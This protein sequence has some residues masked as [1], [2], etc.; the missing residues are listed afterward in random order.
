MRRA[1]RCGAAL[2]HTSVSP[3]HGVPGGW[4]GL[5]G[6]GPRRRAPAAARSNPATRGAACA[7]RASRARR[8]AGRRTRAG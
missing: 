1:A 4:V 8:L 7:R 2:L 6:V 5:P 3:T